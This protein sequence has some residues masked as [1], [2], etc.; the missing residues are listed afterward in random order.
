MN[1]K[2]KLLLLLLLFVIFGIILYFFYESFLNTYI[3]T[4]N[5]GSC[6]IRGYNIKLYDYHDYYICIPIFLVNFNYGIANKKVSMIRTK[7][8]NY[9]S[10]H[11]G[12]YY[13][14]LTEAI[15]NCLSD[16][17]SINREYRV[18]NN[19]KNCYILY[20]NVHPD[21]LC[22]LKNIDT[23]KN[24]NACC[25]DGYIVQNFITK[26]IFMSV[27]VCCIFIAGIYMIIK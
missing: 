21:C 8:F 15:N 20:S 9:D 7:D 3:K 13:T 10:E 22:R 24:D 12:I 5:N 25:N 27:V 19:M 23:T 17:L 16:I 1:K 2:K 18:G 11:K 4:N 14:N 26:F 6:I